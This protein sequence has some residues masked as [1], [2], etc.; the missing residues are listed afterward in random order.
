MGPDC[1]AFVAQKLCIVQQAIG[2][3]ATIHGKADP[4][5]MAT[6]R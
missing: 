5:R 4:I 1:I 6:I 3:S 2:Y